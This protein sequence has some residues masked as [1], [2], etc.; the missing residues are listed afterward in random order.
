MGMGARAPHLDRLEL[1][2]LL[3]ELALPRRLGLGDGLEAALELINLLPPRVELPAHVGE[4]IGEARLDLLAALLE[5]HLDLAERLQP[6]DKVVV[7]YAEVRERLRL[8]LR[9]F[10]LQIC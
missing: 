10:F 3:R 7:E 2:I 6:R 9:A 8:A 4:L 1:A 5:V